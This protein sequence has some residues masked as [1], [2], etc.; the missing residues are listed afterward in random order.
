M[1]KV[2][3]MGAYGKVFLVNKVSN[4]YLFAMKVIKKDRIK[5]DK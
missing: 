3:G 2:L 5:T 4:N 1:I